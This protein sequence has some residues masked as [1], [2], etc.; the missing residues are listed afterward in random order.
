[1]LF[2]TAGECLETPNKSAVALSVLIYLQSHSVKLALLDIVNVGEIF[3]L[4]HAK[5]A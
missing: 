4:F 3:W 5:N 1:M 2:Q